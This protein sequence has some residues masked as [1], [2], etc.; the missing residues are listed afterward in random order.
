MP[1]A[2][3]P[4]RQRFASAARGAAA[5]ASRLSFILGIEACGADF[6]GGCTGI[7]VHGHDTNPGQEPGDCPVPYVLMRAGTLRLTIS[8]SR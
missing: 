6:K 1:H 5:T 8:A 7:A 4:D 3:A 2:A